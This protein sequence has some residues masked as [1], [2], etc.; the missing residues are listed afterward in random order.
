M[1]VISTVGGVVNKCTN[2]NHVPSTNIISET[3]RAAEI[4]DWSHD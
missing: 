3:Y 4:N 1:S 2:Y